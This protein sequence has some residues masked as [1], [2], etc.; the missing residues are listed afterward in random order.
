M[1]ETV[2]EVKNLYVDFF[3]QNQ[4]VNSFKDL[5]M[6]LGFKSPF[7]RKAILKGVTLSIKKGECFALMGKNGSGKSTLLRT[8]AGIITPTSGE[9][10]V[11]GRIAPML[12]I[13]AGLEIELSGYDNIKIIATLMGMNNSEIKDA[14]EFVETFSELSK[15]DL[16]MQ[17]KR[18]SAGMIA[19]LGFSIS[20]A[21]TPDI[22][23]VDEVRSTGRTNDIAVKLLRA[24]FPTSRVHGTFWMSSQAAKLV[25]KAG[26]IAFG[27]ADLPV[28]YREDTIYGRGVGDRQYESNITPISLT[29]KLGQYF[30]SSRLPV[31]QDPL[32]SQLRKELHQLA[33][34]PDVP[35]RPNSLRNDYNER[36]TRLNPG[37]DITKIE[38]EIRNIQ[39]D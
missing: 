13:G 5:V 23:I 30:L 12:S 16:G 22:L 9:M 29:Q 37:K 34:H 1:L 21:K 28:W 10:T 7:H 33:T 39:A 38:T 35:I 24:A 36:I 27:N 26:G 8:L 31:P 14:M 3:V 18:Y 19:R 6:S 32:S 2:I 20:V 17:V 15:E 4:A 25:P 11:N